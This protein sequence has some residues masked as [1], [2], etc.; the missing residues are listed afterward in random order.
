MYVKSL[1]KD[2]VQGVET[3]CEIKVE[4]Q[5]HILAGGFNKPFS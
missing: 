2:P 3:C 4:I 5:N 1:E